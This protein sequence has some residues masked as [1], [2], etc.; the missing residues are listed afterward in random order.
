MVAAAIA[1]LILAIIVPLG[2]LLIS[3]FAGAYP[4]KFVVD[5]LAYSLAPE[6]EP[7]TQKHILQLRIETSLEDRT[8]VV[9][10]P[11]SPPDESSGYLLDQVIDQMTKA[12][13]RAIPDEKSA[14]QVRAQDAR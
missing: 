2:I 6:K 13:V 1:L 14:A 3:T 7:E 12:V 5:G 9:I 4:I 10:F 11:K 8:D